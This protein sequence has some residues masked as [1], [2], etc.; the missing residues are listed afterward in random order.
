MKLWFDLG[1]KGYNK[2]KR[3]QN[4]IFENAKKDHGFKVKTSEIE[5]ATGP[6]KLMTT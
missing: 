4:S 3:R 6:Q 5:S 2:K 1:V